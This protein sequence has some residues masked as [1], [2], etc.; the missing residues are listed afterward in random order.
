MYFILLARKTTCNLSC[1]FTSWTVAIK[2][3]AG[4]PPVTLCFTI[5]SKPSV[6]LCVGGWTGSDSRWEHRAAQVWYHVGHCLY[7]IQHWY[8]DNMPSYI[9]VIFVANLSKSS[10]STVVMMR[11]PDHSRGRRWSNYRRQS[12]DRAEWVTTSPGVAVYV[13]VMSCL[14]AHIHLTF[15]F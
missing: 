10:N 8:L 6:T 12:W 15:T 4:F 5:N 2:Q 14:L 13:S 9:C 3:F 1:C 7:I 11:Y